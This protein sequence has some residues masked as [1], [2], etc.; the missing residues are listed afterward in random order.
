MLGVLLGLR[1]LLFGI[2]E[3]M[4]GLALHDVHSSLDSPERRPGG[5]AP[6]RA[7]LTRTARGQPTWASGTGMSSAVSVVSCSSVG[8]SIVTRRVA[9]LATAAS[10]R[11]RAS[12][13]LPN[14]RSRVCAAR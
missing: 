5:A 2:A 1:M 14:P 7:G 8:S 10:N 6:A 9:W 4:F 13:P 3:I 11:L 12:R